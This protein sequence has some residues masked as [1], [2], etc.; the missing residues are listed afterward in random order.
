MKWSS[1]G[2]RH[3]GR[4]FQIET[5]NRANGGNGSISLISFLVRKGFQSQTAITLLQYLK[6]RNFFSPLRKLCTSSHQKVKNLTNIYHSQV[7]TEI[8]LG[9]FFFLRCNQTVLKADELSSSRALPPPPP[10]HPSS[11]RAQKCMVMLAEMLLENENSKTET[12]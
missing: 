10:Q 3:T 4:S 5:V 8:K 9:L 6:F 1:N 11:S 7:R 12:V 2:S